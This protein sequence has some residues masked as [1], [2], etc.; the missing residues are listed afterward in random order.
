VA[1]IGWLLQN[2]LRHGFTREAATRCNAFL[3]TLRREYGVTVVETI[4]LEQLDRGER[5]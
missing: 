2:R 1:S 4:E 5:R 3:E